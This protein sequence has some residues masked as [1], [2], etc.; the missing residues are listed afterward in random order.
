MI[1]T[2]DTREGFTLENFRDFMPDGGTLEQHL[3]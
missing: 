3:E 2:A 1:P